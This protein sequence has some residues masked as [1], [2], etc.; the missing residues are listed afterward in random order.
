M[1]AKQ[2]NL[3]RGYALVLTEDPADHDRAAVLDQHLGLDVLRVYRETGAVTT[4]TESC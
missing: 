2:R 4:P 3:G 1:S